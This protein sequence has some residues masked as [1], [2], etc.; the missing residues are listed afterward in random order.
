MAGWRATAIDIAQFARIMAKDAPLGMQFEGARPTLRRL[1]NLYHVKWEWYRMATR[2]RSSPVR[3]CIEAS[4]ACNLGCPHCF[5]GAGETSRPRATLSLSFY[6]QLLAEIGDR[7]WHIEFHNWGEPLLN[8]NLFTMVGE[9]TAQGLSTTFCT[10]FSLPFDEAHADELVRSGLKVLGVS[11]DGASQGVY[12]QYRVHG[13][14]DTVL[15]NCTLVAAA[16]RRLGSTTPRM[17]WGYHVFPHNLDEVDAARTRAAEIGMDFHASRGRVVGPDWD[18]DGHAM[19]HDRIH[20]IP[21]FTLWHTAVVYADGSVAPCRGSF[22]REDD[23]AQIGADGRPGVHSFAEAWNAERFQRARHFFVSHV[24]A[25]ADRAHICASC[26][27]VLDWHDAMGH[28]AAGG[29]RDTWQ[30]KFNSNDRFNY[31]WT[32]RRDAPSRSPARISRATLAARAR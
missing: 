14:L 6:R 26:P 32:R 31:F 2:L 29:T 3:L 21:C 27:Y 11:I 18:S 28:V 19:P 7:L 1:L 17:V 12:A 15:R 22:Y 30:P 10:N 16:K 25:A 9:A 4:A 13:R 24:A 5:T 20:P 8:R 23:L